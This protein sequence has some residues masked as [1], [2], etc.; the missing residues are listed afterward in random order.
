MQKQSFLFSRGST[1]PPSDKDLLD[2]LYLC[3][4]QRVSR[5]KLKHFLRVT[6]N[7]P[8]VT[9]S[10]DVILSLLVSSIYCNL[11]VG[12]SDILAS[13]MNRET[14]SKTLR[15]ERVLS[16]GDPNFNGE[17]PLNWLST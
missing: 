14:G 1:W 16:R 7:H 3:F 10:F 6:S 4:L 2:S 15:S 12:F 9:F 17:I 8:L 11:F 13:M 5:K